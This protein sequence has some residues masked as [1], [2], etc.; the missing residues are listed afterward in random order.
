M[1]MQSLLLISVLLV[2]PIWAYNEDGSCGAPNYSC[3]Q[4]SPCCSKFGYCG[5]TE[6]HCAPKN[7]LAN[8]WPSDV[9]PGPDWTEKTQAEQQKQLVD[10]ETKTDEDLTPSQIGVY[11]QWRH[12]PE[13]SFG[14]YVR[15]ID[16]GVVALTFDD[17]P[18]YEK[19]K[20]CRL[21]FLG[22]TL[23]SF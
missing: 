20:I 11:R 19:I 22:R 12:F 14:V 17:G 3:P 16:P 21:M 6:W 13:E 23:P 5:A 8:C 15:C 7:C 2:A 1:A 9:N 10:E 4:H 18:S